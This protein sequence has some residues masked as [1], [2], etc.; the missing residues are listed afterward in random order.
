MKAVLCKELGPIENLVV[1]D[2]PSLKASKG[3]VVIQVKACGINFPDILV[4]QGLYQFK[5][6]LPFSPGGEV[7]GIIKEVGEGVTNLQ[8]GDKVF[9][10]V[11]FG[12]FA[13]EVIAEASLVF[14]LPDGMDFGAAVPHGASIQTKRT[15]TVLL[16]QLNLCWI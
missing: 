13:E 9:A 6:P 7:A 5:P 4:V 10:G 15:D 16:N 2:I 1:E 8:V 12:G 3:K 14:P 11:I